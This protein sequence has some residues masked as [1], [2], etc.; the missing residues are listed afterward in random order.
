MHRIFECGINALMYYNN[1]SC[2]SCNMKENLFFVQHVIMIRVYRSYPI[3]LQDCNKIMLQRKNTF[4]NY[5]LLPPKIN[6]AC[7]TAMPLSSQVRSMWLF[8]SPLTEH[9]YGLTNPSIINVLMSHVLP[10]A[11]S[12][13]DSSGHSVLCPLQS[14]IAS[15][16]CF[17]I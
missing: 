11:S 1:L 17:F 13:V 7:C 4:W 2:Q 12:G 15:W 6:I 8:R 9:W 14:A 10:L 3:A 5:S 16:Y